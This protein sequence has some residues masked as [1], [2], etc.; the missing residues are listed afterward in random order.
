MLLVHRRRLRGAVDLRRRDE[1]EALDRRLADRVEQDLRPLDVGAHELGAAV[2]DRLLDVGLGGG[3]DDHVNV[4]DDVA[5]EL[6]VADV[7]VDERQALVRHHVGE[8]L[9]VAGIG[10]RVER[11]DVVRRVRQQVADEVR[12]D[13][14]GAAGDENL[15]QISSAI[16]YRGLPSTCRWI[17]PRYSPTRARMKPWMPRTKRISVPPKSGPG[18]LDSVIQKTTP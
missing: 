9:D 15:F 18:K 6:G 4:L 17:L 10:Q 8:V 1:D 14:A 5:H 11:D 2:E 12:R 3:V 16:V 13:E 7:A